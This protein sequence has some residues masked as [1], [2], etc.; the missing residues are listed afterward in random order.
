MKKQAGAKKRV[1]GEAEAKSPVELAQHRA[2]ARR[3][4]ARA[5][6]ER[7]L[8]IERRDLIGRYP[9]TCA[10]TPETREHVRGKRQGALAR[11][12]ASGAISIEQLGAALEIAAVVE[13]IG[14]DV[15]VRTVSLETRVDQS[16][17][18][19]G[20]FFEALGQVRREV[21]YGRWRA[22]LPDLLAG[23]PVAAVLQLIVEDVG[24]TVVTRAHRMHVRRVRKILSD[25]LDAWPAHLWDAVREVDE[26][27][28]MA[29]QSGLL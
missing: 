11:L 18:G 20:G 21:A 16:M 2:W 22:A 13:R 5:A 23:A 25:A 24:V 17:C 10:A 14:S 26:A 29:A 15:T 6:E 28:L 12:Y 1:K 4:P 19:D 9:A 27:T 3:H 7:A 8:R